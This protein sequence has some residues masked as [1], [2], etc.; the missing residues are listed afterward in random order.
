MMTTTGFVLPHPNVLSIM[1]IISSWNCPGFCISGGERPKGNGG[2]RR[3]SPEYFC[4]YIAMS[5]RLP[6]AVSIISRARNIPGSSP[7]PPYRKQLMPGFW[8]RS[9][10]GGPWTTACP[11]YQKSLLT[12]SENSYVGSSG[13]TGYTKILEATVVRLASFNVVTIFVA[14]SRGSNS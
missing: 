7:A 2:N 9:A 11:P 6:H 13:L 12:C 3:S 5:S 1:P 4:G 10:G 14:T 8:G